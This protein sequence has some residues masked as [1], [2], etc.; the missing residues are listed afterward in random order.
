MMYS[1]FE[2]LLLDVGVVRDVFSVS[3]RRVFLGS[4]F[5]VFQVLS[6]PTLPLTESLEPFLHRHNL[7][8]VSAYRRY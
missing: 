4:R 3:F 1:W 5:L 2:D 6:S 8:Q 7:A